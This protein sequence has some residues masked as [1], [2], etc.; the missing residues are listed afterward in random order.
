MKNKV[1][2]AYGMDGNYF[3]SARNLENMAD[4]LGMT[5]EEAEYNI[6]QVNPVLTKGFILSYELFARIPRSMIIAAQN[7][8]TDSAGRETRELKSTQKPV[9]GIDP[10]TGEATRYKSV[11]SAAETLH[12]HQSNVSKVCNG[13]RKT[14]GGLIFIFEAKEKK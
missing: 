14:T 11:K 7:I 13:I 12:V 6:N 10:E 5:M 1:C 2:Y 4:I 3:C 9:I 8:V